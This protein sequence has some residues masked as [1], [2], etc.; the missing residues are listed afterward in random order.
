M[1]NRQ[2]TEDVKDDP[3]FVAAVRHRDAARAAYEAGPGAEYRRYLLRLARVHAGAETD[4]MT[5]DQRITDAAG[6]RDANV[7][8]AER[9]VRQAQLRHQVAALNADRAGAR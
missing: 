6:K 9:A 7:A 3:A 2:I 1:T 8:A 4:G 5:R